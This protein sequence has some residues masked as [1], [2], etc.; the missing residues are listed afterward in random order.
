MSAPAYDESP[1][2]P[3][4]PA[5]NE[6]PTRSPRAAPRSRMM[7][8]TGREPIT[9]SRA[10]SAT[11]R[12]QCG[13]ERLAERPHR[14]DLDPGDR[15]RGAAPGRNEGPCEPEPCG[16]A[17]APL[18][19]AHRPQLTQQAD[20]AD[21]EGPGSDRPVAERG[22]KRD[23]DGEVQARIAGREPAREIRID[24]SLI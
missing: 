16:L 7:R 13:I 23:R 21:R 5:T 2:G 19:S 12:A 22:G 15:G 6:R 24:L 20:L 17:Q 11:G 10:V 8:I 14:H 9:A 18:E 1:N 4:L 3:P